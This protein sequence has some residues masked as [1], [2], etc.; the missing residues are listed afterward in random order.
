MMQEKTKKIAL[1][2]LFCALTF[3]MTWIS[4]PAPAVGNVNLGDGALLLCAHILGGPWA[5]IAA[6]TGAALTDL[7][8]AYA[9]Y[10]PGTF[11]IKACMVI[12]ALAMTKLLTNCKLPSLVARLIS[13]LCAEITMIAGYLIYE[14]WILSYGFPTAILNVPFNAVQ[15]AIAVALFAVVYPVLGKTGLLRWLKQGRRS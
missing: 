2:A 8:S 7:M 5:A 14:A 11:V 3:A 9:I 13:A 1:S 6:A 12:V 4:V 10:A 15:G